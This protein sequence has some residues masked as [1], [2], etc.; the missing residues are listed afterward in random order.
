MELHY[1]YWL[2][3]LSGILIILISVKFG[4]NPTL[5]DYIAFAATLAG[6][7]LSVIAI[8]YSFVTNNSSSSNLS[9]LSGVS[10]AIAEVSG[11]LKASAR[12]ISLRLTEM[13]QHFDGLT[14]HLDT[15]LDNV[16]AAMTASFSQNSD[17]QG[18][19]GTTQTNLRPQ[20]DSFLQRSSDVG[21][22]ALLIAQKSF[23]TGKKVNLRPLREIFHYIRPEYCIGYLVSV[24]CVGYLNVRVYMIE[25]GFQCTE[26]S[27]DLENAMND[28]RDSKIAN[29]KESNAK[30]LEAFEAF[31]SAVESL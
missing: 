12:E 24:G 18:N 3:I 4:N 26:F 15:R 17:R 22:L 31:L 13:P 9:E 30:D 5:V 20:I 23:Q 21:F 10:K 19:M 8:F 14:K 1:K 28:V 16:T 7:L 11:E 6:L 2:A 27:P 29:I 25:E